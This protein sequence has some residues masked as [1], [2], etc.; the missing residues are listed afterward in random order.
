MT[1]EP[2][3]E[4]NCNE[5]TKNQKLPWKKS[6]LAT[7]NQSSP[8]ID[9]ESTLSSE[10]ELTLS[11]V[12]ESTLRSDQENTLISDQD[13]TLRSDHETTLKSDPEPSWFLHKMR[14]NNWILACLERNLIKGL[15]YVKNDPEEL[16]FTYPWTQIE[17]EGWVDDWDILFK[18]AELREEEIPDF[19]SEN[20][21]QEH[22]E[23]LGTLKNKFRCAMNKMTQF[24]LVSEKCSKKRKGCYTYRVKS[25]QEVEE[26]KKHRRY[27]RKQ[28]L[29]SWAEINKN[30]KKQR[31]STGSLTQNKNLKPM[32]TVN[33]T[34]TPQELK[35]IPTSQPRTFVP[36]IKNSK[37][38]DSSPNQV[39]ILT[40]NIPNFH[41]VSGQQ[42]ASNLFNNV[43][44]TLAEAMKQMGITDTD[45]SVFN[46]RWKH[47]GNTL[48]VESKTLNG[49]LQLVTSSG[50][51]PY[52]GRND[53]VMKS[54]LDA[55]KFKLVFGYNKGNENVKKKNEMF[56]GGLIMK[57]EN[58]LLSLYRLCPIHLYIK[59][60][61]Q[62]QGSKLMRCSEKD[63]ECK[64]SAFSYDR[65][66][67]LLPSVL[68]SK[69]SIEEICTTRIL[70]GGPHSNYEVEIFPVQALKLARCLDENAAQ[71][72]LEVRCSPARE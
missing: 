58:N 7:N 47:D 6:S 13:S 37:S 56:V 20:V 30:N 25:R 46:I 41:D 68:S 38:D 24:E 14:L 54:V 2:K 67:Q 40:N 12:Q 23:K 65:Y 60:M 28:T 45:L 55:T 15:T 62:Q 32:I 18:Y 21:S 27:K 44:L 69:K 16:I 34:R 26:A 43:K 3:D 22:K 70:V 64:L 50:D 31:Y 48:Q 19:D 1:S 29:Q 9:Q 5:T 71:K 66:W 4:P 39:E 35:L 63:G 17:E 11:S 33:I 8:A 10:Q 59:S 42:M 72:A 61:Y 57:Y 53:S 51:D 36:S 52:Y 49:G